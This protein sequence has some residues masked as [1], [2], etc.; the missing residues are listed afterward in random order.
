MKLFF[1]V[2]AASVVVSGCGR[3]TE[4]SN[5]GMPAPSVVREMFMDWPA[6]SR[7]AAEMMTAKYGNA[8]EATPT[9]LVWH[10]VGSFKHVYISRD[11]VPHHFPKHHDDVM[12]QVI[13]YR[14][15]PEMFDELAAFDGSVIVERTK[16]ELSARCDKEGANFLALNLAHEI[17]TGKRSVAEARQEYAAQI[18]A[19]ME[20]RPAPLT[21]RLM[22]T[23][24]ANAADADRPVM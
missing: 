13:S 23:L 1:I 16:G 24:H 18:K 7:M 14:V 6:S 19:M 8:H 5:I 22:F 21:E 9:M 2:C 4:M 11:P 20:N 15:P 12:E 10:N 17:I 3:A